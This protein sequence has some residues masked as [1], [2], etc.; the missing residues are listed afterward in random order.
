M[1]NLS[2]WK[3]DVKIYV[4]DLYFRNIKLGKFVANL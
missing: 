4:I 1:F 3:A 2:F